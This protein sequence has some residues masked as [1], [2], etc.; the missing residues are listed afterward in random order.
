[1][2]YL[3]GNVVVNPTKTKSDEYVRVV[4][5]SDTHLNHQKLVDHPNLPEADVFVH[6]GDMTRYG[7]GLNQFLEV[8]SRL[9]YETK[10]VITGNHDIS[11]QDDIYSR[12]ASDVAN[13][14]QV[15]TF[16]Q[17][18]TI[19]YNNLKWYGSHWRGHSMGTPREEYRK[20]TNIPD[21]IDI[22]LTH[23]PPLD[24]LDPTGT[25]SIGLKE[26]IQQR[27]KPKVHIFGHCHIGYG[28]YCDDQTV[29][30]NAAA[31]NGRN[32]NE[33]V[34]FDVKVASS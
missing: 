29:Y 15:A 10:L 33:L 27:V 31:P 23:I 34:V 5:V 25:G 13:V 18:Q 12:V 32:L 24:I 17:N 1:M 22:L 19:N 6:C 30:I 20:W 14:Q 4:C 11:I 9:P 21:D 8:L 7:K 28:V 3:E 16:L 26:H 2:E